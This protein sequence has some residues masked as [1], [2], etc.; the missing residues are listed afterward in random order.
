MK[1]RKQK[2][3]LSYVWSLKERVGKL[4]EEANQWEVKAKIS[5]RIKRADASSRDLRTIIKLASKPELSKREKKQLIGL[6]KRR[7]SS[8]KRH[9][10]S[11]YKIIKKNPTRIWDK[12]IRITEKQLEERITIYEKILPLIFQEKLK[13]PR[14]K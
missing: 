10:L 6:T 11:V 13:K 8:L 2:E 7:L 14:K 4:R 12:R 1:D 3:I 9:F 5:K